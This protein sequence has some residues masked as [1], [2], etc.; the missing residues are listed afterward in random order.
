MGWELVVEGSSPVN[1]GEKQK[2]RVA[3]NLPDY[4][5]FEKNVITGGEYAVVVVPGSVEVRL[6][7]R[8]KNRGEI[9][10][11]KMLKMFLGLFYFKLVEMNYNSIADRYL[12]NWWRPSPNSAVAFSTYTNVILGN[13]LLA[14]DRRLVLDVRKEVISQTIKPEQIAAE[15]KDLMK[16]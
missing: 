1:L 16:S 14:F 12:T 8:I 7:E 6:F 5:H 2:L 15:V 4:D 9:S 13:N 11:G 3:F 10:R